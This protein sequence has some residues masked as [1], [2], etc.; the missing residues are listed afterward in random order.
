M[1]KSLL[2]MSAFAAMSGLAMGQNYIALES[3]S[4]TTPG[5]QAAT[6][7]TTVPGTPD[8]DNAG[9]YDSTYE[10]T[11]V[12][13]VDDEAT[14][15][16]NA[17]LIA[18][19]G[20]YL[21]HD[22]GNDHFF[23]VIASAPIANSAPVQNTG[24]AFRIDGLSSTAA[25][26]DIDMWR[27]LDEQATGSSAN[28][29]YVGITDGVLGLGTNGLSGITV[30]DATNLTIGDWYVFV[31]SYDFTAGTVEVR[32]ISAADGSE[33]SASATGLTPSN[34]DPISVISTGAVFGPPTGTSDID[35]SLDDVAIYDASLDI[36]GLV[37]AV[38]ADF[39]LPAGGPTAVTEWIMFE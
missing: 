15:F 27:F 26:N 34:T 11:L 17:D 18:S 37:T 10:Y 32:V 4:T 20:K 28:L 12:S 9:T 7:G 21:D 33:I 38:R 39:A 2:A 36:A 8:L 24:F 25:D 19:D 16:P 30:T 5:D 31:M 3:F 6:S 1:K 14:D 22:G 35:I 29:S 23:R 13:V